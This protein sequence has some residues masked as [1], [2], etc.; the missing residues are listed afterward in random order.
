M[1]SFIQLET[2]VEKTA[3]SE[4]EQRT[5]SVLHALNQEVLRSLP[6]PHTPSRHTG[7]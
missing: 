7:V 2:T 5:S 4:P 3:D 6:D 1:D